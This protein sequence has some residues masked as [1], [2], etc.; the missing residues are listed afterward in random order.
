MSV[1]KKGAKYYIR[2]AGVLV[3]IGVGSALLIT[4]LNLL[5]GPVIAERKANAQAAAFK[6]VFPS[7]TD[8]SDPEEL[9]G[10]YVKSY[11]TAYKG[12]DELGKILTAEG[13]NSR[14]SYSLLVGLS[15]DGDDPKIENVA[16]VD[17][18]MTPGYDTTFKTYYDAFIADKTDATLNAYSGTGATLSCGLFRDMV[19]EA[20][21][22]YAG[23]SG[24]VSE[25]WATEITAIYDRTYTYNDGDDQSVS[26][27]TYVKKYYPLYDDAGN[28]NE[29]ARVYSLRYNGEEGKIGFAV[30]ISGD[31]E[32]PVVSEKA[33]ILQNLEGQATGVV[34]TADFT[35]VFTT[36]LDEAKQHYQDNALDTLAKKSA[37]LF[38]GA[39]SNSEAAVID[40][41]SFATSATIKNGD[42]DILCEN[43]GTASL[44]EHWTVYN[45]ASEEL[46]EVYLCSISL[47]FV[48]NQYYLEARGD[49]TYLISF[50]YES[51]LVVFGK[52]KVLT[53]TMSRG[54]TWEEGFVSAYNENPSGNVDLSD[55]D[56]TLGATIS[57]S[58]SQ[59][60]NLRAAAH[61]DNLKKGA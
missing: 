51:D 9:N 47:N 36:M 14:A 3:A 21:D 39:S 29:A 10:Q 12:G 31:N 32:N 7:L 26:G 11:R 34:N 42:E 59:S 55:K 49:A 19:K 54:S 4:S 23:I 61:Y 13:Q 1:E 2:T 6:E 60:L 16:I 58:A 57:A 25:D 20:K 52:M 50:T 48:N 28:L 38:E 24:G 8:V 44:V 56:I 18:E 41:I 15:G 37:S 35:G 27:G 33:Y 5:T 43:T 30:G 46:G 45:S 53:D 17:Q 22:L 40:D